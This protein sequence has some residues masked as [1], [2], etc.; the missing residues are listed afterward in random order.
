MSAAANAIHWSRLLAPFLGSPFS[1]HALDRDTAWS[2]PD[3]RLYRY[4]E[5]QGG[6]LQAVHGHAEALPFADDSF[7]L[8]TCQTVLI[9]VRDPHVAIR[10]MQRVAR[11]AGWCCASSPTI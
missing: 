8:V 9:H 3:A 5:Q 7:D 10:E 1:V 2:R 6:R 4:F 11:P